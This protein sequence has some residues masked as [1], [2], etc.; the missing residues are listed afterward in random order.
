MNWIERTFRLGAF[1][2]YL[3]FLIALPFMV[4]WGWIGFLLS[5]PID[6]VAI[7]WLRVCGYRSIRSRLGAEGASW[8]DRPAIQHAVSEI[9]RRLG[10]RVPELVIKKSGSH[11]IGCFGFSPNRAAIVVTPSVL[12]VPRDELLALVA[13]EMVEIKSFRAG[14]RSWFAQFVAVVDRM[15][16][17][18]RG[19]QSLPF[20]LF[21]KEAIVWPATLIPVWC[22]LVRG[23]ENELDQEALRIA[24]V[25]PL[26]L[27]TGYRRIELESGRVPLEIPVDLRG[28]FLMPPRFEES[29]VKSMF[30]AESLASRVVRLEQLWRSAAV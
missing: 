6:A 1:L 10:I 2:A 29:L 28:L 19:R 11:N 22:L 18:H 27:A 8:G 7:Y 15:I 23:A 30:P 20:R 13:R 25:S 4:I 12:E 16:G 3:F 26:V 5:L 17:S 24:G 21:L 14:V 9:A